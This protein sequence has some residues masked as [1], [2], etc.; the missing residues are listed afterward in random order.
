MVP[1]RTE[2]F[3]SA[4]AGG[5]S[6]GATFSGGGGRVKITGPNPGRIKPEVKQF[7]RSISAV[8][9]GKPVVGSDGTGHSRLTVNRKVSE[10]TTGNASDIPATGSELTNLGQAALIAAGVPRKKARQMRGGLYN[11]P[12]KG[13]GR[14]QIIFNTTE[15]GNHYDHLH[16]GVR[17]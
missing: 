7:M 12:L 16:V 15:G 13:G 5:R 1:Q 6:S 9:G 10:H 3:G 11:V 17:R 2:K 4:S 14:V 8:R